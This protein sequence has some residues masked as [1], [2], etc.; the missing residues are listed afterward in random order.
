M[1]HKGLFKLKNR[2][3]YKGDASKI[4]FRSSWERA[5]MIYCDKNENIVKWSSEQIQIP[6]ISRINN[7]KRRRYLI[8][9]WI[10]L[11]SGKEY[12]LEIKPKSQTSEP[13]PP[14]V[15]TK[16]SIHSYLYSKL[17]FENNKDKWNAAMA[18]AA[19]N[20]LDF[21]I[22]TEHKLRSWGIKI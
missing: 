20:K 22:V 3:K 4:R 12:I 18:F 17:M 5:F 7:G 21:M 6:Y 16:K 19:T 8:D 2:Q 10:R 14:K 15:K 9:F 11:K 1:Y 13:K